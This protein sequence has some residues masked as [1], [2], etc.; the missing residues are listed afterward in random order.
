[1]LERTD[2]LSGAGWSARTTR[3]SVWVIFVAS[4]LA[5]VVIVVL[6]T[7]SIV[8]SLTSGRVALILTT[9]GRL[10]GEADAG[11]AR[12]VEGAYESATVVLENLSGGTVAVATSAAVIGLLRQA[13]VCGAIAL[14]AWWLLRPSTFSRSLSLG[15]A[16]AGG[17]L[18]IGG[19]LSV[20]LGGFA[21]W[22]AAGELNDPAA[23][24]DGF[25]PVSASLNLAPLMLGFV[26]LLVGLAL[27]AGEKLQ[28]DNS[29]LQRDTAGLV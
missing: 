6:G 29:R 11:S 3:G 4:A 28:D 23:G 8:D 26:L 18:L 14:L 20:G 13:A 19:I 16:L 17:V 25:W 5:G 24:L 9:S 2:Q 15:I 27:E 10:P 22:M 21:S 12:I 7:L 1:M